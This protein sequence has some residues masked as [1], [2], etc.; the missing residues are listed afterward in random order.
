MS[1]YSY[2]K[3]EKLKKQKLIDALFKKRKSVNAYP[4]KAFYAFSE[5]KLDVCLKT[6][7]GTSKRNFKKAVDRNRVKRLLREA[8][9]LNK[10]VLKTNLANGNKQM[11]VFLHYTDKTLPSLPLIQEK[12]N[13]IVQKL[14][15]VANENATQNN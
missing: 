12:V 13:I 3:D 7:V 4:V 5:E 8:W 1:D 10:E 11:I 15:I 9:R 14:I 6:G 2:S